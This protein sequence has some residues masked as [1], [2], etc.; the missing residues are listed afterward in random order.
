MSPRASFKAKQPEGKPPKI[1]E[2]DPAEQVETEEVSAAP[3]EPGRADS[4]SDTPDEMM[5][6][7]EAWIAEDPENRKAAIRQRQ[8]QLIGMVMG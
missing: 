1:I 8:G 2:P 6:R 4:L 5:A 7:I 3:D